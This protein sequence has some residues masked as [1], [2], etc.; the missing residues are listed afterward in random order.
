MPYESASLSSLQDGIPSA[1]PCHCYFRYRQLASIPAAGIYPAPSCRERMP[2]GQ[3]P[4]EKPYI[5]A[6]QHYPGNA[7]LQTVQYF[8]YG[9]VTSGSFSDSPHG[10]GFYS[11]LQYLQYLLSQRGKETLCLIG[12]MVRAY[13]WAQD[14]NKAEALCRLRYSQKWNTYADTLSHLP[15]RMSVRCL[16]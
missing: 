10:Q 14:Y 8:Q 6:V 7:L 2:R 16:Y 11:T 3:H 1:V 5:P 4:R 9:P 13:H 15:C 12:H